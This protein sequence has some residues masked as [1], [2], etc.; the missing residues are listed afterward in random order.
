[1][2]TFTYNPTASLSTSDGISIAK[3]QTGL[4]ANAKVLVDDIFAGT[5]AVDFAPMIAS[6]ANPIHALLLCAGDGAKLKFDGLA[7]FTAKAYTRFIFELTPNSPGPSGVL[8]LEIE[9]NGASTQRVRF[10]AVGD[11]D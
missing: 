1:M 10:L 2:A 11:P 6:I 4:G 3:T 9:T 8:D 7:S 5:T